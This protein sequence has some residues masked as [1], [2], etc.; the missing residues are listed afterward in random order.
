MA[1]NTFDRFSVFFTR[2]TVFL[3]GAAF[4]LGQLT[5]DILNLDGEILTEIDRRVDGFMSAVWMLL[6][7]KT[8]S[9]A[10][11]AQERLNAVWD[12]IFDLPVYRSLRLNTETARNLLP[13]LLS[14]SAKWSESLDI[15]SD[16]LRLF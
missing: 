8:D 13:A 4:P 6:Q 9:A 10:R 5:T 16:G 7:E 3:D 15:D 11:S 1:E 2:D 12:L 14:D